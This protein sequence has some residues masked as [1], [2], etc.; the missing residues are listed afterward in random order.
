MSHFDAA[1]AIRIADA[2]ALRTRLFNVAR[3]GRPRRKA[4]MADAIRRRLFTAEDL[5]VRMLLNLE[6][7][8]KGASW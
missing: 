8:T 2:K 5:A 1:K 6:R 3:M 7:T 4:T